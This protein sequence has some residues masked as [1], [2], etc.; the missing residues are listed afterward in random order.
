M[1][2]KTKN[3]KVGNSKKYSPSKTPKKNEQAK[4][5]KSLSSADKNRKV[6]RICLE[7]GD[8]NSA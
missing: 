1:N 5:P 8:I 2:K 6:C 7:E 3:M 4:K